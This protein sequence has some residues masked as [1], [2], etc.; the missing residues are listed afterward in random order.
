MFSCGQT[1]EILPLVESYVFVQHSNKPVITIAG[2]D[3]ITGTKEQL[4]EGM[5]IFKVT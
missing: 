4:D 3:V 2:K 5:N 1:E